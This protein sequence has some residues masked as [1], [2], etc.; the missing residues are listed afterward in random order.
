MKPLKSLFLLSWLGISLAMISVTSLN[1][2]LSQ[3]LRT[4]TEYNLNQTIEYLTV[5][6]EHQQLNWLDQTLL[7]GTLWLGCGIAYWQYPEASK[8]LWHYVYGQGEA[9][10]LDAEYF[11][12]SDY[13]KQQIQQLG[14]GKHGPL[15][16]KQAQD[17]RL[18]LALNPYYL[19]I[20][21][22]Q[23]K[24]YHPHIAFAPLNSTRTYTIL[25]LGY[26]RLRLYD[27]LMQAFNPK[28]F[29]VSASWKR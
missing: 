3:Q 29:A 22:D 27:N 11:Q 17:W 6:A 13:L 7:H 24:L 18:S 2:P 19:D 14:Q 12:Q 26:L 4:W 8:I 21:S 5:K 1:D 28:P 10:T 20:N 25:P 16:L 23:V 15:T 9:L